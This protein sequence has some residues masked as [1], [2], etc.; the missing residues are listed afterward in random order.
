M[1]HLV[2]VVKVLLPVIIL[3]VS[4]IGNNLKGGLQLSAFWFLR[5]RPTTLDLFWIEH[6][7]KLLLRLDGLL[8]S[9]AQ[10]LNCFITLTPP[11]GNG[12]TV[13]C[14]VLVGIQG[15]GLP[16]GR[17]DHW[18]VDDRLDYRLRLLVLGLRLV[19]PL[20]LPLLLVLGLRLLVLGG[21]LGLRLSRRVVS[22]N[23]SLVLV[24]WSRFRHSCCWYSYLCFKFKFSITK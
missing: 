17:H 22:R 1:V 4:P 7:H 6:L 19:L 18:L 11:D 20:E 13:R 9:V 24:I 8:N 5:Q 14:W 21:G 2:L 23:R 3:L 10:I 12:D 16:V 15:V